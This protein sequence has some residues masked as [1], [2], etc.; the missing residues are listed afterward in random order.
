MR[1]PCR[2]TAGTPGLCTNTPA[3]KICPLARSAARSS[4]P[5]R[6]AARLLALT[7]R[8][9]QALARACHRGTR[10]STGVEKRFHSDPSALSG[11]HGPKPDSASSNLALMLLAGMRATGAHPP[12]CS[13]GDDGC[14]GWAAAENRPLEQPAAH[15]SVSTRGAARLTPRRHVTSGAAHS[16]PRGTRLSTG[17]KAVPL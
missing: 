5:A 11:G 16:D 8:R 1:S 12:G 14:G 3:G 13:P 7:S 9:R 17:G 15:S 4:A 10:L 6:G 2:R